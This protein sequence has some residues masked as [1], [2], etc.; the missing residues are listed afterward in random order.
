MLGWVLQPDWGEYFLLSEGVEQSGEQASFAFHFRSAVTAASTPQSGVEQIPEGIAEHV[1]G[2]D[3]N[4]QAEPGPECQPWG[5]L[6]VLT[7]FPT[8]QTP[9]ARN[10]GW[11]PVSEKAQRGLGN[12][13]LCLFMDFQHYHSND[14]AGDVSFAM[15]LKLQ[16]IRYHQVH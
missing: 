7:P 13:I 15:S 16:K 6:H 2:V 4:R 14:I 10:R 9:P 3:G 11:Q 5:Y 12:G 1:E 8:E